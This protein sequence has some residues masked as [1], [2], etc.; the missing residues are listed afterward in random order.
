MFDFESELALATVLAT[1]GSFSDE[2]LVFCLYRVSVTV[3][4]IPAILVMIQMTGKLP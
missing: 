4:H 2:G 3:L 1:A